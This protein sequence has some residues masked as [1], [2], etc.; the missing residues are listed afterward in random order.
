MPMPQPP[1]LYLPMQRQQ[2]QI[3]SLGLDEDGVCKL[4]DIS[5]HHRDPFDRM[6]ICQALAFGLVIATVDDAITAYPVPVLNRA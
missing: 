4:A 1:G 2:H 3:V 5:L 6:L